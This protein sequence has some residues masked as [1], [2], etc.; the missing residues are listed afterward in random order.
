[1]AKK[2]TGK[3]QSKLWAYN[4][5]QRKASNVTLNVVTKMDLRNCQRSL[6]TLEAE[7]CTLL[8]QVAF[9]KWII[10]L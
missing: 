10:R 2:L 3:F 8:S 5:Y 4:T 1:M 9:R 7:N 6:N